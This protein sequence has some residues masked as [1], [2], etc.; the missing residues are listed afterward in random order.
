MKIPKEITLDYL[1]KLDNGIITNKGNKIELCDFTND[2]VFKIF[3]K[4]NENIFKRFLVTVLHLHF[5]PK[6]IKITFRDKELLEASNKH[7][8]TLDYY[9]IINDNIHVDLE[10]NSDYFGIYKNKS[11]IYQTRLISSSLDA[12][13]DYQDFSKQIF[14]Q[15]NLNAKEKNKNIGEEV[16]YPHNVTQDIIYMNNV[17]IYL[18]YLDF[19]N[20]LF[21]TKDIKKEESDY[22]LALLT[23]KSFVEIYK[24][25]DS[26][27]EKDIRDEIIRDV[28]RISMKSLF[29]EQELKNLEKQVE[30][31]KEK[32]Y[33]NLGKEEGKA[34]GKIEGKEEKAVEIA[35]EMLSKNMAIDL[36][37]E[38]TGL[39]KEKVE[40]LSKDI[41]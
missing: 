30:M 13:V 1:E 16:I 40:E 10:V 32:F 7:A 27:L 38:L 22:W 25:L 2:K 31:D 14:I 28:I 12:G 5:D 35:K 3:F 17:I 41:N 19:Y 6:D 4:S 39:S 18:R 23:S 33:T 26:F 21:Y 34:E 37:S 36:I 29:T 24:I 15:L 11:F 20:K 9:I 8:N